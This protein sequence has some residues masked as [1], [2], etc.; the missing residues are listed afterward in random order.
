[1][2]IYKIIKCPIQQSLQHRL[3]A[4]F[5]YFP[6]L[7]ECFINDAVLEQDD[8]R[9]AHDDACDVRD[10]AADVAAPWQDP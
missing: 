10:D 3:Q 1:M 7:W 9:D 4:L 2:P 6:T 8:A 5:L